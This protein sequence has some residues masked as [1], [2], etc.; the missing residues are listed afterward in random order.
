MGYLQLLAMRGSGSSR[1]SALRVLRVPLGGGF[2]TPEALQFGNAPT[3]H[4]SKPLA[5][6]ASGIGT[7]EARRDGPVFAG[8]AAGE[9]FA[10]AGLT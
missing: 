5:Q 3:A 9:E 10:C 8:A 6:R 7:R 2:R 1:P 4:L